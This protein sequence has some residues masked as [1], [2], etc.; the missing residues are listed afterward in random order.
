M[1]IYFASVGDISSQLTSFSDI[2]SNFLLIGLFIAVIGGFLRVFLFN[3]YSDEP[4]QR[5]DEETKKVNLLNSF[6][7]DESMEIE[8][9]I[10]PANDHADHPDI[11]FEKASSKIDLNKSQQT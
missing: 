1:S 4:P 2:L 3:S 9:V 5:H 7:V 8:N 6:P 11:S 10:V